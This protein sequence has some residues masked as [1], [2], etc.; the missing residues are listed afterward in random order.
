MFP[1][2]AFTTGLMPAT[3]S[4]EDFGALMVSQVV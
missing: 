4:S 1:S 2:F 3:D